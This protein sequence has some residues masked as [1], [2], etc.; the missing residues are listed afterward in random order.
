MEARRPTVIYRGTNG[1]LITAHF[2]HLVQVPGERLYI[3]GINY[4]GLGE[5]PEV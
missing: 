1:K 4:R 5:M 3:Y 2:E